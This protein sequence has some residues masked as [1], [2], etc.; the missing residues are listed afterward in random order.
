M[1]GKEDMLPLH[2]SFMVM[3]SLCFPLM[4]KMQSQKF[5]KKKKGSTITHALSLDFIPWHLLWPDFSLSPR[6]S[7]L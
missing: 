7:Q 1:Q 4:C 3:I 6:F 5:K 2:V